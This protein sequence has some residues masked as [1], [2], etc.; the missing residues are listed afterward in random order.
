M[1]GK[2]SSNDYFL[3][4]DIGSVRKKCG[5]TGELDELAVPNATLLYLM[6]KPTPAHHPINIIPHSA[7][8]GLPTN[9][10]LFL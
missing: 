2:S 9:M 3:P 10:Q 6:G 1:P 7:K 5:K 8:N 4:I